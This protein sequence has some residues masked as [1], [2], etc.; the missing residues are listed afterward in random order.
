MIDPVWLLLLAATAA[1]SVIGPSLAP[2]QVMG[3]LGPLAGY[4]AG[5][6]MLFL[7]PVTSAVATWGVM[8]LLSGLSALA[9]EWSFHR[10][11]KAAGAHVRPRLATV[12][13]AVVFWPG[14]LPRSVRYWL[15]PEAPLSPE[16]TRWLDEAFAEFKTKQETL[17]RDWRVGSGG[18]WGFDQ[19]TGIFTIRF[20][21]GAEAQADGQVLGSYQASDGTWEWAW[22]N[23][24]VER[25][26]AQDSQ[27]VRE[28]G[29]RLDIAYL[30]AGKIPAPTEHAVAY[31]AGIGVKATGAIGAYRGRSGEVEMV[32]LLKNPRWVRQAVS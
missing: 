19:T 25:P 18:E 28:V 3:C 16:A 27:Q 31:C 13:G 17:E 21:D 23:P 9:M 10:K 22:N 1:W 20:S 12:I 29:R 5:L 7:M 14:R 8:G 30:T 4:L 11:A 6:A 26:V 2:R 24:N 32:I 15:T